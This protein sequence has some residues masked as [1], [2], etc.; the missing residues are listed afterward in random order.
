MHI[1]YLKG[2]GA[3]L[4][5]GLISLFVNCSSVYFS[6]TAKSWWYFVYKVKFFEKSCYYNEKYMRRRYK[7]WFDSYTIYVGRLLKENLFF[8]E[9]NISK[10]KMLVYTYFFFF[11][12]VLDIIFHIVCIFLSHNVLF[13]YFLFGYAAL[14]FFVY[15][16]IIIYY[17]FL[18]SLYYKKE[19]EDWNIRE[20]AIKKIKE[21][22]PHFFD[23]YD[24]ILNEKNAST[25]NFFIDDYCYK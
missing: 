2:T 10:P 11:T 8:K 9:N 1:L 12:M 24:P 7:P 19:K 15:I 3:L 22:N 13:K 4:F 17:H 14:K 5:S 25:S 21:S 16:S 18:D 20:E 23:P 6:D